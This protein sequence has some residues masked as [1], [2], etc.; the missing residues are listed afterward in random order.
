M[1]TPKD[2]PQK[3]GATAPSFTEKL[4]KES[5]AYF[6]EVCKR[7]FSQQCVSFLNAYWPE[8]HDQAE[9]LY[10]VGWPMMKHADMHCKGIC[11]L[12]QY[13][14]GFDLDFDVGLYFYEILCKFCDDPKN[15]KYKIQ[16][17]SSIPVM[18]TALTRKQ[19]L[20]DKAM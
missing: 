5:L 7:P 20:R 12:Y 17:P 11:L 2:F 9:F 16:Y 1:S 10:S 15:A 18:M 6:S 14:E 3:I 13:E 8:V 4:D 19:E